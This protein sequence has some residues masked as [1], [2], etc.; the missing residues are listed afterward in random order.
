MPLL[1]IPI[2]NYTATFIC[3]NLSFLN[4]N[5]QERSVLRVL[6]HITNNFIIDTQETLT[7]ETTSHSSITF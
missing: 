1:F 6:L 4:F 3:F 5:N 7:E 2:D